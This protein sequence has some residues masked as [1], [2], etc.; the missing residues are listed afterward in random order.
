MEGTCYGPP[1]IGCYEK[2][3]IKYLSDELLGSK[4]EPFKDGGACRQ[5]F[6]QSTS[7]TYPKV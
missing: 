7:V 1:H 3:G 4:N 2:I 6:G 5:H